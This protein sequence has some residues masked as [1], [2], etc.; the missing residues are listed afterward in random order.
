MVKSRSSQLSTSRAFCQNLRG[1]LDKSD[2]EE[3]W[4]VVR[5]EQLKENK[6]LR[7]C[8]TSQVK[9]LHLGG[10]K[11]HQSVER[12]VQLQESAARSPSN[13]YQAGIW[14]K[15]ICPLWAQA[16]LAFDWG[17][18]STPRDNQV[19][20]MIESQVCIT[21]IISPNHENESQVHV[22]KIYIPPQVQIQWEW[23]KVKYMYQYH[24]PLQGPGGFGEG[25]RK[26]FGLSQ[27]A[28][29][30]WRRERGNLEMWNSR[31]HTK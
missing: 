16:V 30:Q 14:F 24:I 26:W 12:V 28:S 31:C 8:C 18:H 19:Q 4:E 10:E 20:R 13:K 27:T 15:S 9:L 6:R 23:L 2:E 29:G 5:G 11:P 3:R 1:I 22:G 7:T 21:R 25:G 17:R